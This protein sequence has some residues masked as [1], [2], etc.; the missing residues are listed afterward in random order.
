MTCV[1]KMCAY[2]SLKKRGEGALILQSKSGPL[3]VFKNVATRPSKNQ[4]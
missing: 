2:P 4:K 3:G 1:N